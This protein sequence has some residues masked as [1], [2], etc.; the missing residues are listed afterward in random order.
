MHVYTLHVSGFVCIRKHYLLRFRASTRIRENDTNTLEMRTVQ[1]AATTMMPQC[2]WLILVFAMNL[3][4]SV[5]F[6]F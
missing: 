3:N 4:E 2:R 1:R 6:L 5:D